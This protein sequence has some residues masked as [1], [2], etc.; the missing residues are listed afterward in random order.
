M[1]AINERLK[2]FSDLNKTIGEVQ[3]GYRAGFSTQ[4]HIFTLHEIIE[5]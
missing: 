2:K 1:K 3:I 4:D 5:T